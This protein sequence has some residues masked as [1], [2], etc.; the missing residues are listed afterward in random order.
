MHFI[1]LMLRSRGRN[2]AGMNDEG[3]MKVIIFFT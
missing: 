3:M 2:D 1:S